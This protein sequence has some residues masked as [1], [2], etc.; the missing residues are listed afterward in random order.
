MIRLHL[1]FVVIVRVTDHWLDLPS[2]SDLPT[3]IKNNM[4]HRQG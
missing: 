3:I 4:M 1:L 2:I